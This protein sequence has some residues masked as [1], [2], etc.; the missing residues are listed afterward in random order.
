MV[1]RCVYTRLAKAVKS[2]T[3]P[4]EDVTN[5]PPLAVAT[6][7]LEAACSQRTRVGGTF[8]SDYTESAVVGGRE[9]EKETL[10]AKTARL[11]ALK[12]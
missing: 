8:V 5:T 9:D 12:I 1:R 11:R 10:V 6:V 3:K 2:V 4:L 7:L